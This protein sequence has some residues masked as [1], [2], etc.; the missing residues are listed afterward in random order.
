MLHLGNIIYKVVVEQKKVTVIADPT[1]FYAACIVH[2]QGI[3]GM[4]ALEQ[5]LLLDS[6]NEEDQHFINDLKVT[7]DVLRKLGR[8]YANILEEMDKTDN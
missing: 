6:D 7:E 3:R 5:Q 8:K 4:I 1:N 2:C